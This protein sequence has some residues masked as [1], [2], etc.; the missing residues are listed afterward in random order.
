[1]YLHHIQDSIIVVICITVVGDTVLIVVKLTFINESILI[2][3][4][5]TIVGNLILL[6]SLSLS[7]HESMTPLSLQST[8]DH[9]MM[10]K[11]SIPS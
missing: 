9:S 4:W 6:Q 10:I 2:A 7:S 3:I 1:M 11:W 8:T 5:F